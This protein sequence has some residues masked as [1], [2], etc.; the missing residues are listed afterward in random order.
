[1]HIP[2]AVCWLIILYTYGIYPAVISFFLS[3]QIPL[4]RGYTPRVTIAIPT[5]NEEKVIV[6]KLKNTFEIEYPPEKI[7]VIVVDDSTDNTMKKAEEY[8]RANP[9]F[10]AKLIK[11]DARKGKAYALNEALKHAKG[12]VFI[13]TDAN[14][15]LNITSIYD[16]VQPLEDNLTACVSG[17]RKIPNPRTYLELGENN[18]WFFDSILRL[19]ES[20]YSNICGTLGE[21]SAYRTR[22]LRDIGGFDVEAITEDL[23]STIALIERGYKA[24]LVPTAVA[25][26]PAP[27]TLGDLLERRARVT[28]GTLQSLVAFKKILFNPKYG[29]YGMWIL[30]SHKLLPLISPFAWVIVFSYF[31]YFLFLENLSL[32][33]LL[34]SPLIFLFL[35]VN[36]V[37][38]KGETLFENEY[39]PRSFASLV[40]GAAHLLLD[41]IAILIGLYRF[42]FKKQ[43]VL[44]KK[45]P[46]TRGR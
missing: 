43:N 22:G 46:S 2:L 14:A 30:P 7:E 21:L 38:K 42:I 25:E 12:D 8:I 18:F 45:L 23:S 15:Q 20:A 41:N 13:V 34:M 33:L 29:A 37:N 19:G 6:S 24:K 16:I 32:V 9:E 5:Y 31:V 10:R 40:G 26:E 44:W 17:I 11:L 39:Y 27:S 1:M 4:S 35:I 3:R 28:V 36:F